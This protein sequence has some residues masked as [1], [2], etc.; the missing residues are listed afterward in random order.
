[1]KRAVQKKVVKKK[2]NLV[3]KLF[4]VVILAP[5]SCVRMSRAAA[6]KSCRSLVLHVGMQAEIQ[7]SQCTVVH[8]RFAHVLLLTCFLATY[9]RDLTDSLN[10]CLSTHADLTCLAR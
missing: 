6:R 4:F 10:G 8:M 9:V 1:M 2:T 5:S 3:S 7:T